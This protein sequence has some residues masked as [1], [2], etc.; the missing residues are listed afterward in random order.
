[1]ELSEAM[2]FINT[3]VGNLTAKAE[4][5]SEQASQIN[6]RIKMVLGALHELQFR[7]NSPVEEN[8]H[9]VVW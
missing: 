6:A 9:K 3:R 5:L 1:M 4:Q 7:P 8:P 2:T